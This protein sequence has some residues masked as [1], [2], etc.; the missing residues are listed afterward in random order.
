MIVEFETFESFRIKIE[1]RETQRL[2]LLM[3]FR[4]EKLPFVQQLNF[5]IGDFKF[6]L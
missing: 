5:Q 1:G 3:L 6:L 2:R 4:R